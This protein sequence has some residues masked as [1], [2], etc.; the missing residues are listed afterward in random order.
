MELRNFLGLQTYDQFEEFWEHCKFL[1]HHIDA[2]GIKHHLYALHKFYVEL[3]SDS[4]GHLDPHLHAFT[5]GPRLDKYRQSDID[6]I[7]EVLSQNN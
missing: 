3:T 7:N 6:Y 4:S 5:D 1:E 2:Y